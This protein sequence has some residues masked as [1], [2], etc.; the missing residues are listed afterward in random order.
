MLLAGIPPFAAIFAEL[1]PILSSIWF[2]KVYYMFGF[3]FLCYGLMIVTCATTTILTVYFLLCAENYHWHWRAFFTAGTSAVYIFA[4]ALIYWFGQISLGG[5]AGNVL[6]L[7][8]SLLI[9]FLYFILTGESFFF[10]VVSVFLVLGR[11]SLAS[12]LIVVLIY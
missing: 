2:S 5:W 4:T 7:G 6:Y 1:F 10:S 8:Y 12:T 9:S 11:S 3:L